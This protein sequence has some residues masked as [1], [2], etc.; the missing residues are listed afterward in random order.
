MRRFF[1][2]AEDQLGL[3]GCS[4]ILVLLRLI[5]S[6]RVRMSTG[7]SP[8]MQRQSHTLRVDTMCWRGRRSDL[9]IP[10]TWPTQHPSFSSAFRGRMLLLLR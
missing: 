2:P 4:R 5:C 7:M 3:S 6:R 8:F 9:K 1:D 10:W